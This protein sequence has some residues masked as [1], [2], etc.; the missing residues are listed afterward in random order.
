M[1]PRHA[2]APSADEWPWLRP[3]PLGGAAEVFVAGRQAALARLPQVELA[4]IW[5]KWPLRPMVTGLL[6]DTAAT[7]AIAAH[8]QNCRSFLPL[9]MGGILRRPGVI[10][11]VTCLRQPHEAGLGGGVFD[12]GGLRQRLLAPFLRKGLIA[13]SGGTAAVIYRPITCAAWRRPC[14]FCAPGNW[15]KGSARICPPHTST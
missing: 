8:C 1:W 11:C 2:I 13:S 12:I 4:L 7:H 3:I 15:A 14:P 9:E 6:P 10:D 5:S